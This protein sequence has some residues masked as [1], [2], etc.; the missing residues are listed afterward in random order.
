MLDLPE[1]LG[2]YVTNCSHIE[3]C[4]SVEPLQ[5]TFGI[6]IDIDACIHSV[7]IEIEKFVL[8]FSLV[9]FDWGTEQEVNLKGVVG[10]M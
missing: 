1:T 3:C 10:I 8:E 9:D 7:A 6:N 4:M 2:C 5:Q